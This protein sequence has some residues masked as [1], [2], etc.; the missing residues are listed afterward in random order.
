MTSFQNNNLKGK[1]GKKIKVLMFPILVS[2]ILSVLFACSDIIK[3]PFDD[4]SPKKVN[5]IQ[6]GS[7]PNRLLFTCIQNILTKSDTRVGFHDRY[8]ASLDIQF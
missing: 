1:T 3:G 5:D 7:H 8:Q 4:K 2:I 6:N